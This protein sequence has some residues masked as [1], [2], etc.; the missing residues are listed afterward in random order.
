MREAVEAKWV[1]GT[2]T[3]DDGTTIAWSRAGTGPDLV[4]VHCVG[5]SRRTTPQPTLADALSA[6]FTV[7]TY[8]RRGKGQSGNADDYDVQ[9]EI[10]DLTAIIRLAS[11]P[12]TV[13]GFSS[14][15]TLSLIAAEAGAPIDRLALLEPPLYDESDPHGEMRA[16]GARQLREGPDVLHRWYHTDVVGVPEDVLAELG[17]PSEES[18]RDAPTLLHELSFLP[19]TPAKRFASVRQ[20][21]LVLAS[22]S[23]VPIMHVWG[24]QLEDA[25]PRAQFVVL[26]GEWHGVDDATLVQAIGVFVPGVGAA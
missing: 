18:L 24:R 4:M 16:E 19:G 21:T 12:V 15:A 8:D 17:P 2:I 23:T 9:R 13:Y 3:S 14:G 11:G 20:P 26:P 22:D 6:R 1:E 25:L 10:D 5:V 7:W